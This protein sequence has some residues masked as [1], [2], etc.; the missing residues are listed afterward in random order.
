M[1]RGERLT[2]LQMN[3]S[4]GYLDLHQELFWAG[5]H[6]KFRKAEGMAGLPLS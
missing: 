6:A 2:T 1:S 5:D 4:Q 3:D